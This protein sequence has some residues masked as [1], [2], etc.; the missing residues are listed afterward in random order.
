MMEMIDLH[1]IDGTELR[2]KN[3]LDILVDNEEEVIPKIHDLTNP[4]P[5]LD[6]DELYSSPQNEE[7]RNEEDEIDVGR[8]GSVHMTKDLLKKNSEDEPYKINIP[9]Q[10]RVN[11]STKKKLWREIERRKPYLTQNVATHIQKYA[12][13]PFI[14][15]GCKTCEFP[16]EVQS[17]AKEYWHHESEN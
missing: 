7:T 2:Q 15:W 8:D 11:R 9:L 6:N 5:S 14:T 10:K 17:Y 1:Q 12:K 4:T 13:P 3:T 16:Y